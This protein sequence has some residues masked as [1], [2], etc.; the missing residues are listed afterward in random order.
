MDPASSFRFRLLILS[1]LAAIFAIHGTP[2]FPQQETD[3]IADGFP[4]MVFI[5]GGTFQMGSKTGGSD[6]RPVH[7]VVLKDFYIG[8]YEVTQAQ[9]KAVMGDDDHINYFEGCPDCPVERVSWFNAVAFAEK[10]AV[11]T[12]EKYRLPTEA[13]WEFAARGGNQSGLFKYSGSDSTAEVAWRND[14][15]ENMTHPVGMKK[16]NESGTYDMSGNVWEWCS[17]WYS[18]S[19]YV[20]SPRQNPTGPVKGTQRVMRGGSWF[21]DSFGLNVTDRK[22]M[23]PEW[24]LGFVGFRVCK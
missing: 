23:N 13:E 21:Q 3:T 12:G 15:A 22:A 2:A 9:W 10:L 1:I 11:L 5:A 16:S 8:K 17:D 24:R 19:Y 20:V 4:E 18:D 7:L 6:K 14:N